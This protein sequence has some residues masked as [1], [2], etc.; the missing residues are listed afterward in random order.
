MFEY[1]GLIVIYLG[2]ASALT[3]GCPLLSKLGEGNS[4][5]KTAVWL[6]NKTVGKYGFCLVVAIQTWGLV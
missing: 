1:I 5:Y 2:Y 6:L 3:V 4:F